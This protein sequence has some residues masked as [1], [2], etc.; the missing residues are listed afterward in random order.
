MKATLILCAQG[1]AS[2][3]GRSS[4]GALVNAV[5]R[6][7]SEYEVV[8]AFIDI[9][10]PTIADVVHETTGPRVVVPLML[11]HDVAVGSDIMEAAHTSEDVKVTAP[12]GPDWALAEIGVRRLI[13]A[14]AKPDD[15]IVMAAGAVHSDRA[16]ADVGKAAR[17]LSAVWGGRVHVGFMD[18][19]GSPIE[20]ALDVGRAYGK[21]VV[22]SMYALTP[23]TTA[24][25]IGRLGA[26][27]VTAPLLGSGPPDPRVVSLILGRAAARGS[28]SDLGTDHV[29]QG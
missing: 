11:A 20:D 17:L 3:A 14:G 8:D 25:A 28:W 19:V 22:V 9:Q 10:Q 23:G 7:A 5:R 18:G 1:S 16:V 29:A 4:L 13:E 15:T 2:H 12:I 26:D 27:V 6:E 21:R 24:G